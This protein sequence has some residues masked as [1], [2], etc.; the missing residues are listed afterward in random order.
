MRRRAS[1]LLRVRRRAGGVIAAGREDPLL[2]RTLPGGYRVTHLVGVGGMGRVYCAEQVALGRT[3][4]VKVVHPGL[5]DDELTSARFLNEARAASRLSHPNSV[6]IF[7]F[8]RTDDGR[9]YI[10]MEYL[11]GRDLARVAADE[12]PLPLGRVVDVLRQTLAAPRGGARA[13]HR[14]PRFEARQHR[15][16]APAVGA[17]LRQGRRLRAREDPPRGRAATSA[18]ALTRPGLVC[19]TPEYMS[20]EQSRGDPLDGRSDLYSVGVVLFEL[21]TGRVPFIADTATK[22]LLMH[23][24]EPPADPRDVAPE[25]GIPRLSPSVTLRALAKSCDDRF[26]GAREFADALERALLESEGGRPVELG[27]ATGIRCRACGTQCPLG[28]KFCGDCGASIA[29]RL[30]SSSPRRPASSSP[31]PPDGYGATLRASEA[32][33]PARRSCRSSRART[34]WRGSSRATTRPARCSLWRASS[35]SRAWARRGSFASSS[36]AAR[37]A[38]TSSCP[39]RRTRPGRGSATRRSGQ[40]SARS[41]GCPRVRS[42]TTTW[43]GAYPDARMGLESALRP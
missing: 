5:A 30:P 7:D 17:R 12:G 24:T 35:A 42:T 9:P 1:V 25:R 16:R 41:R 29:S 34:P 31:R 4:A 39:Y 14:P 38:A 33:A 23:L 26:Q 20:P 40:R 3:V 22:T 32:S 8:G 15:P 28:Q 13:R 18:G 2:G 10:V 36:P 27:R 43:D 21:L 11:R 6:A 19:G 37:R